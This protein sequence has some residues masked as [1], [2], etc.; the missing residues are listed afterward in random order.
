MSGLSKLMSKAGALAISLLIVHTSFAGVV[1]TGT[2]VILADG[3][4]EKTI[5][6]QNIDSVPALVQLW[7]DEGDE[8]STLETAK[9]P[10]VVSPQI[11]RMEPNAGQ[12][13]RVRFIDAGQ[14]PKDRESLYYLNF[15]QYP[16]TKKQ[17]MENNR[18]MVVFKNR[19]KV[20]YRPKNLVGSSAQTLEKLDFK[21]NAQNKQLSINNPTAYFA[22]VQEVRLLTQQN[23]VVVKRNEM[24]APYSTV[25][26]DAHISEAV[27][28]TAKVK[29]TLVNDYGAT[30]IREASVSP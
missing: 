7:L 20:F 23:Q 17:D 8:N 25:N 13:V 10:F 18:L 16:A 4:N 11:F 2:R 28:T 24:I 12:V 1:L 14:I 27:A 21:F 6:L 5:H 15:L 29:I 26:W 19:V 9:A 3:Q 30:V 22:N